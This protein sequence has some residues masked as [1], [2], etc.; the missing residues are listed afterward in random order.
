MWRLFFR[1]QTEDAIASTE[2]FEG[3]KYCTEKIARSK[4]VGKKAAENYRV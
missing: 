2:M 3:A 1:W 4:E